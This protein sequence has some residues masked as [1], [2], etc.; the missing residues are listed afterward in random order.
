MSKGKSQ[1]EAILNDLKNG[2]SVTPLD[3]LNEHGCFR[4]AAVVCQL[5]KDGWNIK[6]E[7]VAQKGNG[8]KSYASYKLIKTT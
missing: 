1:K 4:L 7:M 6:T 2:F 3:A 5:K 8:G